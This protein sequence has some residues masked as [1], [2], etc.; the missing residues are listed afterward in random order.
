M[1]LSEL[2]RSVGVKTDKAAAEK[3]PKILKIIHAGIQLL[4]NC[5]ELI[6]L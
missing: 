3:M 2:H 4:K 1:F 6:F 5:K